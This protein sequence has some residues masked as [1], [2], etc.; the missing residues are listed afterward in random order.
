MDLPIQLIVKVQQFEDKR[1]EAKASWN[2]KELKGKLSE[3]Y[4]TVSSWKFHQQNKNIDGISS[5]ADSEWVKEP[6]IASTLF[7]FLS[8]CIF[9]FQRKISSCVT[10]A[11]KKNQHKYSKLIDDLLNND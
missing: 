9:D 10:L 4:P 7:R 1:I 8:S 3:I 11:E 5:S 6:F 2:I